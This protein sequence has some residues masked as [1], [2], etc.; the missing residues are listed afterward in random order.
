MEDLD[1]WMY[2]LKEMGIGF[3]N[4]FEEGKKGAAT[5]QLAKFN[6]F[7]A[8]DLSLA[9]SIQQYINTLEYIKQQVYFVSGVTPQRLGLLINSELV[10]T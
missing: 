10:G 2:Y 1:R 3:I 7:Q 4:S 6:Q 8:I 5:G 9:Q